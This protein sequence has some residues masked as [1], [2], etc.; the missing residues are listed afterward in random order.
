MVYDHMAS[1]Q[2]AFTPVREAYV[3]RMIMTYCS[4]TAT[5]C[6]VKSVAPHRRSVPVV[7]A[8]VTQHRSL[9]F[10]CRKLGEIVLACCN[11]YYLESQLCVQPARML[12]S[13]A[14]LTQVC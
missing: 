10:A 6:V 13:Y 12:E 7:S 2:R 14:S 1:L 8:V 4:A 11:E 3:F 9:A 5:R